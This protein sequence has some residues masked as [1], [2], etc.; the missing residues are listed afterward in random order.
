MNTPG[1]Y[2]YINNLKAK[3]PK[4]FDVCNFSILCDKFPIPSGK[5]GY[6]ARVL[7]V[8]LKADEKYKRFYPPD[9]DKLGLTYIYVKTNKRRNINEDMPEFYVNGNT[10]SKEYEGY[11]YY[12]YSIRLAPREHMNN[13]IKLREKYNIKEPTIFF[14]EQL[15]LVL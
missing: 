1:V 2:D 9:L 11:H 4:T 15:D 14:G 12:E 13:I 3:L 6:N 7:Y 8:S 5:Y 10:T